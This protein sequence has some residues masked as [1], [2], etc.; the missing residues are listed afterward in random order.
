MTTRTSIH[1]GWQLRLADDTSVELIPDAVRAALPI[2]ATVPGTVHTDLLAAGLI[3]DPYLDRNEE[4]VQWIG[5][6]DWVYERTLERMPVPATILF[7]GLDTVATVTLDDEILL[8]SRNQHRRY[9]VDLGSRLGAGPA[10]LGIRFASA[11]VF[12]EAE[13]TRLG[14][15]PSQYPHPFNYLRKSA[16]NF[17]WDWG[18]TL[19]TA[20][21]WR[22]VTLVTG[23]GQRIAEVLPTL[24]VTGSTGRAEFGIRLAGSGRCSAVRV[25]VRVGR[26]EV[27]ADVPAG[28]DRVDVAV[29]VPDVER[30]WPIGFGEPTLHSA[31]VELI[32]D[33]TVVDAWHERV[34]FRDIR[35]D[36]MPD[37]GGSEFVIV[38]NDV[39]MP[40]RGVN[41]IPDD[42]FVPR[43]TPERIA[44]R[45][46]QAVD[47]NVNL[48]RV[49]G[50]GVYE[51]AEFYRACDERGLLVWQDFLFACA[52]YPEEER[53]ATEIEHEARDN[54]ARLMPHPSLVLWNGNNENFWGV[55]DWDWGGIGDKPWGRTYYLETLPRAV[56]DVDPTRPY[57]PGSPYAGSPDRHP[58]DEDH[59]PSHIWDVWNELDYPA[60][61][62]HRPRFA[63]EFGWQGPPTWSTLTRAIPAHQQ[64][65]DSPAM[66]SHQKANDGAGKLLRGVEPHLPA[67]QTLEDWHLA[68]QV[69]QARAAA[70]GVEH[71]RALRPRCTGTIV[72]QLN[73]CWPVVSWAAVD[74]D[75]RKK[76]L[77]FALRDAYSPRLLTF[78]PAGDGV[79]L[80]LL[81]DEPDAWTPTIRVRRLDFD[82]EVLAAGVWSARVDALGAWRISLPEELAVARDRSREVLVAEVGTGGSA[83]RALRFFAEDRDLALR[84]DALDARIV[85]ADADRVVVELQADRLVRAACLFP[86]RI[87]PEAEVDDAVVTLLPGE[88]RR[89]TVRGV[90]PERAGELARH[91]VLQTVDAFV[92]RSVG[93]TA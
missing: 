79:E 85:S 3:P 59:G 10:V 53:L 46:D 54:V 82:G 86:D 90:P 42:C 44:E 17:G 51:S 4:L 12:G 36:T 48:V 57:W 62:D 20:G 41:W 49:W 67:P 2:P 92:R 40:V 64:S 11:M 65:L 30:W 80:V 63:G 83:P 55:L 47:A 70:F 81:N 33:G 9:E 56:A 87:A 22:P 68:S 21:I 45:L 84:D 89:I 50:G 75:G 6:V 78:Q 43:V 5:R 25:R 32:D 1:D 71:F 88:T 35:L 66:A 76:P 58:N 29:D 37:A 91:P 23:E 8:E 14:D 18:P 34:G 72:W 39:R 15:Y 77:W 52:T 73:D 93:V 28:A 7:D 19:V 16:C 38:V 24:T 69:V 13:R 27:V 26:E 74:G 31:A 60:Y 61:A